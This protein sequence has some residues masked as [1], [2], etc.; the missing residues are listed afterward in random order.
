MFWPLFLLYRF[1]ALPL[2]LSLFFS[3]GILLVPKIRQGFQL[4][5]QSAK[6]PRPDWWGK[7]RPLWIHAA[8]G[9]FEYAKAVLR[10]LKQ[11]FPKI[12]MVVTY[13]S[14][15]YQRNIANT[16][17][18]DWEEPLPLDT[19]GACTQFLRQC[20]PQALLISR[21]DL[22]PEIL[23][24]C[25]R[26]QVPVWLFSATYS[27]SKASGL[28][29]GLLSRWL[30]PM[31]SQVHCVSEE[32]KTSLLK[33]IAHP[34]VHVSGD[35]RYDQVLHRLAHGRPL[36]QHLRPEKAQ[37][38]LVAGSTWPED[39]KVLL[40]AAAPLLK[41]KQLSLILAPHEPTREH[42]KA[43]QSQ[44]KQLDLTSHLYSQTKSW[45]PGQVLIVDQVGIL[46]DLYSWGRLAFVG[47]SFR[48]SVHSVMEPLGSG[49]L[50]MVGPDHHN[51]REA[52]EFKHKDLGDSLHMVQTCR[53]SQE[54]Q[55]SLETALSP[56]TPLEQ[57][58]RQIVDQVHKKS[59]AS[60]TFVTALITKVQLGPD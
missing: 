37:A 57:W 33:L 32:D 27:G 20:K 7:K 59:G 43:L 34:Q 60:Q 21:T 13:F 51:N 56:S 15:T 1:V 17:E 11:Q 39:E 53:N 38:T 35:T 16:P 25:H 12:P 41:E 14:P 4:R 6:R 18:V 45:Q 24:Q 46:A 2:L 26:R 28:F 36:S 29:R 40:P 58:S 23:Y 54:L 49:A 50:T 8:S 9:E 5:W 55:T 52:L 48:G 42:L 10:E 30:L 3:V 22:W 44:L 19:M 47:G 31:I